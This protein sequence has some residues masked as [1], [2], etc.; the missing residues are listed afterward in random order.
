[1]KIAIHKTKH[2]FDGRWIEY[3]EANGIDYQVVNCHQSNIIEQLQNCDALMWHINHGSPKDNKMA[4]PLLFAL[5]QSGMTV[6][7]DFN[8]GWHFDDKLGQKYLLE[9]LGVPLVPTWIFYDKATALEWINK[10]SF[11]KVFKLRGG[12]GSA[13]VALVHSK[14]EAVAL[15]KTAFGR[16]FAPYN[17]WG[18]FKD[19]LRLYRKGKSTALNVVKGALRFFNPPPAAKM[20]GREKGYIYFQEFIPG[21]DHDI[22]VVVVG[23][24]A[25]AIKRMVRDNDF[26]ASGSGFIVYDKS[27]FDEKL[28]QLSFDAAAKLNTQVFAVDYIFDKNNNPLVVEFSFGFSQ[29]GYEKCEGYWD[30]NLNWHPGSFNPQAW[31]I[32]DLIQTLHNKKSQQ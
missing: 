9:S 3:C 1:M 31:M 4:K 16:G 21:N 19:R 24:R 13:N 10:T 30:K 20:A 2:G 14:H 15:V 27:L 7:P 11:P 29:A 6:F 12:A 23:E 8:T 26:R 32:A 17:A 28:I 5:Q 25:F 22:R 18:N